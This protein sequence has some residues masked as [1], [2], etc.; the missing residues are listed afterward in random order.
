MTNTQLPYWLAAAHLP[1]ISPRHVMRWLAHIPDIE[2]LFKAS[3]DTVHGIGLKPEQVEA[4]LAPPWQAVEEA[5][6]WSQKDQHHLITLDDPRY[7][8]CLKEISDAP[9]VLFVQ[10]SPSVLSQPQLAMVG[11]R[12]ASAT[13][14][15]DA[16]A[17]AYE[18]ASVGLTI[19]SGLAAGIDG[20]SHRGALLAKGITIGV[21]GTGHNNIY[22]RVHRS[23]AQQMVEAGG[24]VI[25]EFPLNTAPLAMNF[26]RRNR[27]IAGLSRGVLVIE[28]ALKSGSLITAKYALEQGRE[29]FAIP[30][31][32]HHPLAH[33]C[34]YL[35]RQ[36]A[37]LVERVEDVLEE[38]R[39]LLPA[40]KPAAT[41]PSP[42]KKALS[43]EKQQLLLQIDYAV[44]PMDVILSRSRLT[45]EQ[46]SSMLLLMELHGFIES[47]PGGY[48][49]LAAD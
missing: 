41:K 3:V 43:A 15:A 31:S 32:I 7:P 40:R 10:G 29:V 44:T 14:L 6:A 12:H 26:P 16:E 11:A 48:R 49:R 1:C 36:G 47:V 20:A 34:H 46:L 2:A 39:I 45:V 25:S 24:A 27:V 8:P 9:L 23:L 21:M 17:F 42:K 33:G 19:T 4:V 38:V 5:L 30:G 28:A 13:G 35:I 18:L 22:P 37:K